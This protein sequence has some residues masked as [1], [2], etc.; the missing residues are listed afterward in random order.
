MNQMRRASD[1]YRE[2]ARKIFY[3]HAK[4]S[5]LAITDSDGLYPVRQRYA[6]LMLGNDLELS[7]LWLLSDKK[8]TEARKL[9][10]MLLLMMAAV[11]DSEREEHDGRKR[12]HT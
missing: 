12:A 8:P 11:A 9:R 3:R 7:E 2:A 6:T 4:F 5:C 10:V 1:I